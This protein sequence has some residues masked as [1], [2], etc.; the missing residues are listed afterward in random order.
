M[1]KRWKYELDWTCPSMFFP[2]FPVKCR[3]D[4]LCISPYSRS[5]WWL[6]CGW[7]MQ[8]SSIC[9]MAKSMADL[10][11]I[12]CRPDIIDQPHNIYIDI[13]IYI[14]RQTH[15]AFYAQHDLLLGSQQS[16]AKTVLV[17]PGVDQ[18]S[19]IF[20]VPKNRGPIPHEKPW[21]LPSPSLVYW[22][23]CGSSH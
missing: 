13:M 1:A 15:C 10:A 14:N 21:F 12:S 9:K 5:S 20:G 18:I 22:V 17:S 16:W 7:F 8:A 11:C 2:D 23:H 3:R 19:M 6:C 4:V